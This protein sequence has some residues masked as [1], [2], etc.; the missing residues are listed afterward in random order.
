MSRMSRSLQSRS[1]A[2]PLSLPCPRA[3]VLNGPLPTVYRTNE[4]YERFL[5]RTHISIYTHRTRTSRIIILGPVGVYVLSVI[6]PC[7][8]ACISHGDSIG[9]RNP[10]SH[11]PAMLSCSSTPSPSRPFPTPRTLALCTLPL[12]GCMR[13]RRP[14][15][16]IPCATRPSHVS[17]SILSHG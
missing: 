6:P 9:G 2:T 13:A 15:S 17:R 1:F 8:A 7:L 3:N 14:G 4:T 12:N 16:T 10:S 11:G 5:T